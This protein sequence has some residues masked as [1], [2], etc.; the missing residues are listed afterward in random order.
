VKMRVTL[1]LEWTVSLRKFF[2]FLAT[3]TTY[4]WLG[5]QIFVAIADE[6]AWVFLTKYVINNILTVNNV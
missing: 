2:I 5:L 6:I 4:V 3:Q 1:L